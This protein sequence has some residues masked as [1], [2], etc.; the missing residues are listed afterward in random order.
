MSKDAKPAA[1]EGDAPP[2]KS[3]KM[4]IIILALVLVL[5][6]GGGAAAFLLMKKNAD[7][8]DEDA[9]E[10][11]KPKKDKKKDKKAAAQPVFSALEPFTVNL[12]PEQGDQYLQV[13]ITLELDDP[14]ADATVKTIMPKIRN[15]TTLL[16]SSKKA[17]EVASKEG[18]EKLAEEL[19]DMINTLIDPPKKG[20]APEGPVVSILFTSFIVQ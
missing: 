14:T 4:L 13:A 7:A 3:K 20:Q 8:E 6:L 10:T 1:A 12:V 19:K 9:E 18:K 5:V 15:G 16:L 17:S 2:K 11:A